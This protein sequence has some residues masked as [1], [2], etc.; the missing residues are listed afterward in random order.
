MRE[1][2]VGRYHAQREKGPHKDREPLPSNQAEQLSRKAGAA[3]EY[4]QERSL[5]VTA[6]GN[7]GRSHWACVSLPLGW[8][9]MHTHVSRWSCVGTLRSL[10]L[11]LMPSPGWRVLM[12]GSFFFSLIV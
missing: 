2:R 6:R 9:S 12:N 8:G 10:G 3:G 7:P 4:G 11:S 1:A 5:T